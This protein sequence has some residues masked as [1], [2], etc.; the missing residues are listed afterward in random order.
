MIFIAIIMMQTL[1]ARKNG[2]LEESI[3]FKLKGIDYKSIS[4][5]IS[6]DIHFFYANSKI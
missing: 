6:A 1:Y 3:K 2:D 5:K 4:Q